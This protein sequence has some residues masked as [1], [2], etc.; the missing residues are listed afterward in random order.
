MQYYYIFDINNYLLLYY[1]L[2][3][4]QLIST[5][6]VSPKLRCVLRSC[7]L[8]VCFLLLNLSRSVVWSFWQ[9]DS[10]KSAQCLRWDASAS[11]TRLLTERQ[12]DAA[13]VLHEV[14]G[15]RTAHAC[16]TLWPSAL[17][18]E[19]CPFFLSEWRTSCVVSLTLTSSVLW[20]ELRNMILVVDE[21]I[22]LYVGFSNY[23]IDW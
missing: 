20:N 11:E 9:A 5:W 3:N 1:E 4:F 8:W 16:D 18:V 21:Y 12:T 15:E 22:G 14:K 10:S 6:L 19:K 2:N 23:R 17:L 13:P 7:C